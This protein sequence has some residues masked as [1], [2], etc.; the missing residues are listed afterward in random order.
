MLSPEV[1]EKKIAATRSMGRYRS[2][3]QVDRQ[4]GR[5]MEIDSIFARPVEIARRAGVPV[6][7]MEMLLFSLQTLNPAK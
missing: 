7:L 2:S 5:P 4:Q 6:P 1:A 3:T